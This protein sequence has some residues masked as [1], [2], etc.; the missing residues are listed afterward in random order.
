LARAPP[1]PLRIGARARRRSRPNGCRSARCGRRSN[2][3]VA[4]SF[5]RVSHRKIASKNRQTL[6]HEDHR[7]LTYAVSGSQA[8]GSGARKG[9]QSIDDRGPAPHLWRALTSISIPIAGQTLDTGLGLLRLSPCASSFSGNALSRARRAPARIFSRRGPVATPLASW[10]SACA[11]M[12]CSSRGQRASLC[13]R[14]STR[15][16]PRIDL[17]SREFGRAAPRAASE[18][19]RRRMFHKCRKQTL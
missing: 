6:S 13:C 17:V 11:I 4:G 7:S 1:I 15:R 19:D 16:V 2:P 12:A 18:Q 9:Q 3:I 5:V 8:L 10:R 14:P